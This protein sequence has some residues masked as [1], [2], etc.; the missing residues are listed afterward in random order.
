MVRLQT[1]PERWLDV[2]VVEDARPPAYEPRQ[3]LRRVAMDLAEHGMRPRVVQ[4]AGGRRQQRASQASL[5]RARR[6]DHVRDEPAATLGIEL[7]RDAPGDVLTVE[8]DL[9]VKRIA[10]RV[11]PRLEGLAM[12]RE[13]VDVD[14][15]VK[16]REQLGIGPDQLQRSSSGG[17]VGW[18]P[19]RRSDSAR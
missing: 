19:C 15:R 4:L 13:R 3:S 11:E 8:R 6:D 17:G 5:A 10:V 14:A 7:V 16:A 18:P 12:R 2:A 9:C 1:R